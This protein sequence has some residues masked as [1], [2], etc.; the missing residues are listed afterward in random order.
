MGVAKLSGREEQQLRQSNWDTPKNERE[1]SQSFHR[2][3][4]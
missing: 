1:R 4:G 2:G 3:V